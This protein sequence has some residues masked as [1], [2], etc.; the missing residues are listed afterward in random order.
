MNRH[1]VWAKLVSDLRDLLNG[2]PPEAVRTESGFREYLTQSTHAG[3]PLAPAVS[4]LSPET[5][6][7]VWRFLDH[8]Q[9]DLDVVRFD[10]FNAAF[11]KTH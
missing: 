5:L 2:L 9:F 6:D 1:D 11:R 3:K 10:H 7:R 8:A 4:A